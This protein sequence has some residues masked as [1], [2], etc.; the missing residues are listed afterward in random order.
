MCVNILVIFVVVQD[1]L[2][3]QVHV[4]I[5]NDVISLAPL[6]HLQVAAIHLQVAAIH[7]QAALHLQAAPLHLVHQVVILVHVKD[8]AYH[9]FIHNLMVL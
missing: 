7:L 8:L 1:L 9:H 4:V 6:R 5:E 2:Q 3:V